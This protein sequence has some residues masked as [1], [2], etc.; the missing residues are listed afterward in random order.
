MMKIMLI[1]RVEGLRPL[2]LVNKAQE[3]KVLVHK[4]VVTSNLTK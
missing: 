4:T 1:S 3:T 2:D